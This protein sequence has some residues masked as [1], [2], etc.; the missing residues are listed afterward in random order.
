MKSAQ[1]GL[2][3][4]TTAKIDYLRSNL[5]NLDIHRFCLLMAIFLDYVAE[6]MELFRKDNLQ[7]TKRTA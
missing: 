3:I 7:N 5:L 4:A 6:I 1:K 2:P